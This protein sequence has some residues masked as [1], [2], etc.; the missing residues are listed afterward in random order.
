MNLRPDRDGFR[1][2]DDESLHDM[3]SHPM[4]KTTQETPQGTDPGE[5][6]IHRDS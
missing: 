2:S 1:E 4:E 3:A 5:I 6:T